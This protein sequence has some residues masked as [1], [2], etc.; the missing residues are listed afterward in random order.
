MTIRAI[1]WDLGGVIVRTED[2]E[3]RAALG[4]RFGMTYAEIERFVFACETSRQASLGLITEEEHW[5]D[6][7]RRLE[8]PESEWR[9]LSADFFAGDRIDRGLVDFIS[10]LRPRYQTG[11]ISNAWS[12]LRDYMIREGFA[13]AFDQIVIS[14]E[15]RIMKPDPRIYQIALEQLNV[16]AADTIFVDDFAENIEAC[17]ALGMQGILFRSAEQAQAD[18]RQK[19]ITT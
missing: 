8:A 12:G 7:T 6:V 16:K 10:A 14:A 4:A 9:A 1:F 18:V 5:Q 3:P 2:K 13:G 11:L 15:S 19:L 17:N